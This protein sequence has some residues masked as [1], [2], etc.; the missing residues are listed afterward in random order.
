MSIDKH[1]S[2]CCLIVLFSIGDCSDK[3]LQALSKHVQGELL[4]VYDEDDSASEAATVALGVEVVEKAIILIAT[5]NNYGVESLPGSSKVPASLSIWRWE[6][7][8]EYKD[9]L[10]KAAKEKVEVRWAERRQVC[11]VH[12]FSTCVS[13]NVLQAR[14]NAKA[15]FASLS[16]EEQNAMQGSRNT[17]R[18]PLRAKASA[19]SADDPIVLDGSDSELK[20]PQQQSD[21]KHSKGVE[22]NVMEACYVLDPSFSRHSSHAMTQ[23]AIREH[24]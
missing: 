14:E 17:A 15:W 9:W 4:P 22:E 3:T 19:K 5:R 2:S 8:D 1:G 6:V 21:K 12:S 16:K 23:L 7:K 18:A 24:T 10:P 20:L 11:S 13:H